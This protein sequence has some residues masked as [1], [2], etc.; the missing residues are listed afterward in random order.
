METHGRGSRVLI[1]AIALLLL[2]G[3]VPPFR[4][5][6]EDPLR[7]GNL[8][9]PQSVDRPVDRDNLTERLACRAAYQSPYYGEISAQIRAGSSPHIE[10]PSIGVRI[11]V[12]SLE[13]ASQERDST[14]VLVYPYAMFV[15]DSHSREVVNAYRVSPVLSERILVVESLGEREV[16]T[17]EMA[18]CVVAELSWPRQAMPEQADMERRVRPKD[19]LCDPDATSPYSMCWCQEIVPAHMDLNCLDYGITGCGVLPSPWNLICIGACYVSCWVPEYCAPW[20]Y[21]CVTIYPCGWSP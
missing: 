12:F 11:V 9:R 3:C 8:G 2:A 14:G 17:R 10:E 21:E 1:L 18:E 5:L 4:P 15:I 16:H 19:Y 6:N 20:A 7:A 13:P